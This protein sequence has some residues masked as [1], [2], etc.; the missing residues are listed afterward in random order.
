M[1]AVASLTATLYDSFGNIANNGFYTVTLESTG[2]LQLLDLRDEDSTKPGIQVSTPDG[3]IYFRALA[4]NKIGESE[5]LASLDGQTD[6]ASRFTI[7]HIDTLSLSLA[8]EVSSMTVGSTT[9]QSILIQAVDAEGKLIPNYQGEVQLK[10]DDDAHGSFETQSVRLS[11]GQAR[12][13]FYA[14]TLSGPTA[15]SAMSEGLQAGSLSLLMNPGPTQSLKIRKED[16]GSTLFA[17]KTSR[18]FVDAY[19]AYGNAASTDQSTQ[20]S[21]RLTHKKISA[22]E[23]GA[24]NFLCCLHA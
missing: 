23:T 11:S 10:V 9:P 3:R 16:N 8:S 1:E 22:S 17:G 20:G 13:A 5:I 14:G 12:V 7:E 4:S 21:L 18:F 6:G 2:G 24:L 19:D 15:L